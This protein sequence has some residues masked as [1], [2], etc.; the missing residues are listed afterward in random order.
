MKKFNLLRTYLQYNPWLQV[1]FRPRSKKLFNHNYCNNK[2]DKI[3]RTSFFPKVI[4]VYENQTTVFKKLTI[5]EKTRNSEQLKE[6]CQPDCWQFL[7]FFWLH[8][9][10]CS[11]NRIDKSLAKII[12]LYIVQA[13]SAA[14]HRVLHLFLIS[15][16]SSNSEF[17]KIT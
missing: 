11:S 2:S 7:S 3:T 4:W 12:F 8:I 9:L 6:E 15:P 5:L 10:L 13:S 14:N 17:L 1:V 16:T